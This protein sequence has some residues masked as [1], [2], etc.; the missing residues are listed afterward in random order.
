MPAY[1]FAG[2]SIVVKYHDTVFT[3]LR[4]MQNN[5]LQAFTFLF[6]HV[7]FLQLFTRQRRGFITGVAAIGTLHTRQRHKKIRRQAE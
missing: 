6:L 1:Q 7:F 4:V 3:G 5:P 2:I